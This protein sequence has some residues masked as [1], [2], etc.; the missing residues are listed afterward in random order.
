MFL[1]CYQCRNESSSNYAIERIADAGHGSC[2]AS[3]APKAHRSPHSAVGVVR[4]SAHR[5]RYKYWKEY[6]MSVIANNSRSIGH[7]HC[8]MVR[9]CKEHAV[10]NNSEHFET[11]CSLRSSKLYASAVPVVNDC[12][13]CFDDKLL[14]LAFAGVD[15]HNQFAD[16]NA[17]MNS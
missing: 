2:G 13:S 4:R 12:N 1:K 17:N 16:S 9:E 10:E 15:Q 3:P 14:S 11:S 7:G 8:V 6:I 5:G